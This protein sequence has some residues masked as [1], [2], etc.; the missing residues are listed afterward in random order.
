LPQAAL[1]VKVD[2]DGHPAT[3]IY[4]GAALAG[5]DGGGAVGIAVSD[6]CCAGHLASDCEIA[7]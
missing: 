5:L 6:N 4:P 2:S 7:S 1:P 3:V